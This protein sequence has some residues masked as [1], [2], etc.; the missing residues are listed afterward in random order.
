MNSLIFL[1]TALTLLILVVT[2]ISRGIRRKPLKQP[3][4]ITGIIIVTYGLLWSLCFVLR[5]DTVVPFGTDICFDD[6]CATVTGVEK[7]PAVSTS[8]YIILHVRV[9]NHARGIAQKPSEPRIHIIDEEG[10]VYSYSPTAQKILESK[11]GI[12][13][14]I[15][16]H[17][18]LHESVETQLAFEL[19]QKEKQLKILI[20]EGPFIT[21]LLFP[22]GN[23]V[24]LATVN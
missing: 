23:E 11:N 20:E 5:K 10:H 19:P 3:L 18:D 4:K 7:L 21:K 13:P 22:T 14:P 1:L 24:F 15:D 17:L 9:S 8:Q 16:Q 6:W 2:I 12:Q